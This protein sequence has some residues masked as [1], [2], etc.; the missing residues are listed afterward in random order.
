MAHIFSVILATGS[1]WFLIAN[2]QTQANAA[3][4][5]DYLIIAQQARP[6]DT[7]ILRNDIDSQRDR[8]AI[9]HSVEEIQKR[10]LQADRDVLYI[11]TVRA[12]LK[13]FLD[14]KECVGAQE[15]LKSLDARQSN[16]STLL[17]DLAS[18]C[19]SASEPT[20]TNL[21]AICQDE[22]TK[23]NEEIADVKQSRKRFS[24]VCPGLGY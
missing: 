2:P 3:D 24:E 21:R 14:A 1:L 23:L 6:P 22:R 17:A 16:V 7:N 12:K 11:R 19:A 4:F 18:E 10:V 13:D 8:E 15:Y 5:R 9:A 20:A